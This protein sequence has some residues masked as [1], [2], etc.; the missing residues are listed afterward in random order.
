[1]PPTLN[2]QNR[3]A[4][5]LDRETIREV[6]EHA[7]RLPLSRRECHPLDRYQG[8]CV[9]TALA[10]YDAEVD[11]EFLPDEELPGLEAAADSNDGDGTGDADFDEDDF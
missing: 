6:I 2:H 7:A 5:I 4:L 11:D 9:N 8:R 10:K 3:F 1:M